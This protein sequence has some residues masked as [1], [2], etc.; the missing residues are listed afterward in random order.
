M[1]KLYGTA[2]DSYLESVNGQAVYEAY[3]EELEETECEKNGV[4]TTTAT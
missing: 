4:I 2:T 1:G 3:I